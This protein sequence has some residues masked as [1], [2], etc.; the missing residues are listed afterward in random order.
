MKQQQQQQQRERE[1]YREKGIR[2]HDSSTGLKVF[3]VWVFPRVQ[4]RAS[5]EFPGYLEIEYT[6]RTRILKIFY[7]FF[8]LSCKKKCICFKTLVDIIL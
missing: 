2:M 4:I 7:L 8:C 3:K 5:W 1:G 6:V